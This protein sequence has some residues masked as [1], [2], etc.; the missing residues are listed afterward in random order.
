VPA[1]GDTDG[2]SK[3]DFEG[4]LTLSRKASGTPHPAVFSLWKEDPKFFK[5]GAMEKQ[6]EHDW[7]LMRKMGVVPVSLI[8]VGRAEG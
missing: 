4:L 2:N 3:P 8:L 5:E 1:A 6:G 7:V